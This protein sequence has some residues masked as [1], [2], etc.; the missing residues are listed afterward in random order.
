[1]SEELKDKAKEM[2][3]Q[4]VSIIKIAKALGVAKSSVSVWTRGIT[5][6]KKQRQQLLHREVSD[7]QALAHSNTFKIRR[8]QF[9]DKGRKKVKQNDPLYI[10][11]CM[12]YWGEGTK[13][14]NTCQM[15]NSELPMLVIFKEF[16]Q[17]FFSVSSDMLTLN[18]NAYTDFHSEKEIEKYWLRGLRLPSTSL[19]SCIWNQYPSSS[20][21]KQTKKSEYGTCTLTVCRTEVVQEIYGAI[22]E[23]GQFTNE[24]W[25]G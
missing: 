13:N 16:L 11:G 9:Q 1:M 15:V 18:I 4:G 20:K 21:K 23:F 12:L 19:R 5:L 24:K 3:K 14:I 8:Q 6:T 2:R 7:E 17:K 22:Q 10:A 25:L